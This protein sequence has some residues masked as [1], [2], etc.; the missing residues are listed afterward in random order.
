MPKEKRN[1]LDDSFT[2]NIDLVPTILGAAGVTAPPGM[3]G[4]DI[5]LLYRQ[6]PSTGKESSSWRE[7]FYYEFPVNSMDI[8]MFKSKSTK[9]MTKKRKNNANSFV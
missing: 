5:S 6:P 4:S 1:T 9:L 8:P 3:Q 7:E 2:L